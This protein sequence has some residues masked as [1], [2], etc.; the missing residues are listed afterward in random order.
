[1]MKRL[2]LVIISILL[3]ACTSLKVVPIDPKTGAFPSST[4]A[5]VVLS[6]SIDLDE[7][8]KIILVPNDVFLK[9]SIINMNYFDEVINYEDLEKII[10]QEDLTEKVPS[11]DGQIGIN[12]AARHYKDFLWFHFLS[13]GE[14]PDKK[15]QFILTDPQTLEDLFVTETHLD[16]VW[17][18]V[19]DQ[20]NWYPMLNSFIEYIKTNSKTYQK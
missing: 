12:N 16:Y 9:E 1:M 4:E 20:Y 18:G 17:K 5:K 6:K 14:N 2:L 10:V 8:K 11:I 13:V 7:R 19:N 3:S 15:A